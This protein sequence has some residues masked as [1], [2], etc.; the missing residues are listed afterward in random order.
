[1]SSRIKYILGLMTI[2]I[3]GVIL[4]QGLWLYKDY[5]YYSGQPLFSKD[6]D[7]FLPMRSVGTQPANAKS[8]IAYSTTVDRS[9]VA[10]SR[11]TSAT[12]I[13]E[14]IPAG[15]ATDRLSAIVAYPATL[16]IEA[17]PAKFIGKDRRVTLSPGIA[18]RELS[19]AEIKLKR[20]TE[21]YKITESGA[22][23]VYRAVPYKAPILH[24]LQKMKWQFGASILLILF[25]TSCFI[26]MLITIFMQRKLSVVKNDMI[27]NMT[28]ELK[29]PLST[30]SVAIE[31]MRNYDILEDKDKTNLYLNVSK[32][33]LDHLSRLIEMIL[34]LSVFEHHKMILFRELIDVNLLIKSIVNKYA[35]AEE[36]ADIHLY[37]DDVPEILADPVHLRNTIRNLIDNAI[38]YS[39]IKPQIVIRSQFTKKGW[40]LTVSDNGIGIPEIYQKSVFDQFFRVPD[41]RLLRVKGFGLGLS[42]VKQV[43]DQ[44]SGT[45]SLF[46][47]EKS[48][49]IF[50]IS[51]PVKL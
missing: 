5:T 44:H 1:M 29:T 16:A 51:I 46:S 32:N 31:A 7:V 3:L 33:E 40:V 20:T 11:T 42:Y 23:Q 41:K 6:F 48:G 18:A 12:G 50:T 45:I 14:K 10:V 21:N 28:H 47:N 49:S 43:I 19:P 37:L 4:T 35:L 17:V 36:P 13:V 8:I 26:Y 9:P 34:E 25:T 38:K 30:V 24:V 39:L 2:C 27:N 22:A 15:T